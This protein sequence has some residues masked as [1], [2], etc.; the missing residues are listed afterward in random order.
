MSIKII[1]VYESRC[2]DIYCNENDTMKELF[3]KVS[4]KI[5]KDVNDLYFLFGG[6]QINPFKKLKDVINPNNINNL[7][8]K[9]IVQ[10]NNNEIEKKKFLKSKYIICPTCKNNCVIK[11]NNYKISLEDCDEAHHTTNILLE[12]IEEYND[13][14]LINQTNIK[15]SFC[16]ENKGNTYESKFYICFT[17]NKNLCPICKEKH[18]KNNKNHYIIDYDDKYFLCSQPQHNNERYISYCKQCHKNLCLLCESKHDKKHNCINFR[19]LIKEENLNLEEYE[20]VYNEFKNQITNLKNIL[21]KVENNLDIYFTMINSIKNNYMLN[22]RNFQILKSAG[23][24]HEYNNKIINEMKKIINETNLTNK[25]NDIID[26]HNKMTKK[27]YNNENDDNNS[28][29]NSLYINKSNSEQS[30]SFINLINDK[31]DVS[32][33]ESEEFTLATTK[34]FKSEE[35]KETDEIVIK[36]INNKNEPDIVLLGDKFIH[37][38]GQKIKLYIKGKQV[39]LRKSYNKTKFD[40]TKTIIEVKLKIDSQLTDMSYMFNNCSSLVSITDLHRIDTSRVKDMSYLFCDCKSLTSFPDISFW[41]TSNVTNMKYLF[42]GCDSLEKFPD[43]S[44]WETSK[45]TDMSYMFCD[46]KEIEELPD[47]SNWCISNVTDLSGMFSG[48]KKLKKLPNLNNW[49]VRKVSNVSY[50]FNQCVSLSQNFV[51]NLQFGSGIK[52]DYYYK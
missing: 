15:C 42:G 41:N 5:K 12:K 18:I 52:K 23:N 17:C 20:K 36:Y 25:F 21:D 32:L 19:D 13:T 40:L 44:V 27:D 46:C 39:D 9:I 33:K 50:M 22:K 14:Q 48:C 29:N 38:N 43:I 31:K 16:D 37:K 10:E 4:L 26:I 51:N 11:M 8:A 3:I 28:N 2:I 7:D 30:G 1:F 47:I 49:D 6:E 35:F 34:K 24:I 45:V